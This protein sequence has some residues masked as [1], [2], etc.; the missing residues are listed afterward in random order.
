MGFFYK[1]TAHD[2][3]RLEPVIKCY[4][5][6]LA[7]VPALSGAAF[8]AVHSQTLREAIYGVYREHMDLGV[9][10]LKAFGRKTGPIS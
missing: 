7:T 1:C 8:N 3:N 6:L 5:D 2:I 10:A 9:R 4:E